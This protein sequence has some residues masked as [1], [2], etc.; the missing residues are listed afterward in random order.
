MLRNSGTRLHKRDQ[1]TS[2][3]RW[4]ASRRSVSC[5][6]GLILDAGFFPQE[7]DFCNQFLRH[8]SYI[9]SPTKLADNGIRVNTLVQKQNEFVITYPRGYHA[10]FN[11]G[12]NCAESVNFALESWLELGKR[13]KVCA[14]VS[15]RCA[16]HR[17][18]A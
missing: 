7:A 3:L 14:C 4:K 9:I 11:M 16:L 17:I 18:P 8:K 1:G 15:H 5:D 13:A 2:N 6:L 10:G 12:F